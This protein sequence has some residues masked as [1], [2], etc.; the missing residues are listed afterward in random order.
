MRA[1]FLLLLAAAG[2]AFAP[3]LEVLKI[4]DKMPLGNHAMTDVNGKTITLQGSMGKHGILIMFSC[5][6]CPWVLKNQA[7]T[8]E[9]CKYAQANGIGMVVLNSNAAQHADKD[10]P[11][12]MKTYATEQ[13]YAWP[14]AIDQNA[15][16]AD[17][18]GAKSTPECYLFD[19]NQKLVY[20]GGI[21][22][23]PDKEA[24]VKIKHLIVAMAAVAGGSEVP[25]KTTRF[26]G[27]SIKRTVP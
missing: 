21:D 27:C 17:S 1:L 8:I 14:Y 4:G 20:H 11:E 3:A 19:A 7:A 22:D 24:P 23:S 9:A 13:G 26:K 10:S 2:L 5:N 18:L 15:T 16:V 12:T 25:N 6:T